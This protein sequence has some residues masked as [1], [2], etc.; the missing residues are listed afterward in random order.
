[1]GFILF[2]IFAWPFIDGWVRKHTRFQEFSVYVG[3]LGAI[4]I[5]G[6]TVWE[7]LVRH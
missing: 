4:A 5:I 3:I 1:M 6:M 2:V 7:A